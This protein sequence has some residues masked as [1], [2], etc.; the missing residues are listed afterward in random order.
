[1]TI[2][3]TEKQYDLLKRMLP[4]MREFYNNNPQPLF[5]EV[6]Q[7]YGA[8][9]DGADKAYKVFS[10]VSV[11]APSP[12]RLNDTAILIDA[13]DAA[14]TVDIESPEVLKPSRFVKVI[15]FPQEAKASLEDCL[16]TF[17]RVLMGQFYIIYEKLDMK[18][19]NKHV[20]ESYL[21]IRLTGIGVREMRDFLI[22]ALKE[23]GWNGSYGIA[24]KDNCYESK[25]AYEMLKVIRK[26]RD[27]YILRI[28]DQPLMIA[29]GY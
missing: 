4:I 8:T 21:D 11:T 14:K 27:D 16:D 20:E 19:G 1:M 25:L 24:G 23:A 17:S 29:E 5:A 13:V 26:R 28:T 7:Q 2:Y 10:E 12:K 3:T 18:P 22:P 9:E 15:R 6:A